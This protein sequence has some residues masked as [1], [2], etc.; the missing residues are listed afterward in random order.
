[1][2][3]PVGID[4]AWLACDADGHVARFTNAGEGP[5]PTAVLAVRELADR[6]DS[7]TRDLPFVGRHEMRVSLPDPTDFSRLARR[8]L[9]GYDWQSRRSDCA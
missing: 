8:G 9:F 6:V 4:Y 5:V 1:M 3:L 7:L 2:E